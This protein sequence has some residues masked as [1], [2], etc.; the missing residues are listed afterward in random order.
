MLLRVEGLG[1]LYRGGAAAAHQQLQQQQQQQQQQDRAAAQGAAAAAVAGSSPPKGSIAAMAAGLAGGKAGVGR[2][3]AWPAASACAP[4]R[5][6][7]CFR[8]RGAARK[9][10]AQRAV[11][12]GKA[13]PP[14]LRALVAGPARR[15]RGAALSWLCCAPQVLLNRTS[16]WLRNR[17]GKGQQQPGAGGPPAPAVCGPVLAQATGS[18]PMKQRGLRCVWRRQVTSAYRSHQHRSAALPACPGACGA[19]YACI[20]LQLQ[21]NPLPYPLPWLLHRRCPWHLTSRAGPPG[22]A[23]HGELRAP[24]SHQHSSS[25][26]SSSSGRSGRRSGRRSGGA[27]PLLLPCNPNRRGC[28]RAAA[29][30]AG[31]AGLAAAVVRGGG[32]RWAWRSARRPA[33]LLPDSPA[34]RQPWCLAALGRPERAPH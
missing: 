26:S 10:A 23:G 4:P 6:P 30:A 14:L 1:H 5:L 19:G 3:A 7:F 12:G 20:A 24:L 18:K 21:T 27:L 28:T 16:Q 31:G 2:R 11:W 25:S 9:Q 34:A 13:C 8:P 22:L 33:A 17:K 15:Q 32:C 29:A